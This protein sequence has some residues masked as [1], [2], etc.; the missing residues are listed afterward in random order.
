VIEDFSKY[1]F[2]KIMIAHLKKSQSDFSDELC[3][4]FFVDLAVVVFRNSP[5]RAY[6][7]NEIILAGA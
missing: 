2:L 3:Q 1:E 7:S 5:F 6:H 4:R